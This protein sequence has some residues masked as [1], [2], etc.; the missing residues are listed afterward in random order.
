MTLLF[1]SLTGIGFAIG[2][3][4]VWSVSMA[5]HYEQDMLAGVIPAVFSARQLRRRPHLRTPRLVGH[6]PP[7]G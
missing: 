5:E 7:D 1:V 2:A 3:M 4:N 6:L